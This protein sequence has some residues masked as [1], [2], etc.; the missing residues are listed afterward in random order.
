MGCWSESIVNERPVTLAC[1]LGTVSMQIKVAFRSI[2]VTLFCVG[3]IIRE[4][5]RI[6]SKSGRILVKADE[7]MPKVEE[8]LSWQRPHF[9]RKQVQQMRNIQIHEET[10]ANYAEIPDF[11]GQAFKTARVTGGEE[12]D[13]V[14]RIHKSD[15]FIPELSLVAETNGE[16][17]GY[18]MLSKTKVTSGNHVHEALL[19]GPVC[20]KVE[21]RNHGLGRELI[22]KSLIIAKNMGFTS[23]FL[24]GDRH[25]Y[26]RFGFVP[27][28]KYGIKCQ[29]D[30]PAELL[31]NIMA[32]ELFPGALAGVSGVVEL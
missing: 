7:L 24:A 5:G 14:V 31:D 19:L 11:V 21:M 18:I 12:R 17:V 25:Y 8:Y 23:V 26:S 32:L 28:S 20:T 27:A 29:Y 10:E 13:M 1:A 9:N 30:I 15:R 6:N 4:S 3:R 2:T 16:L 22:K